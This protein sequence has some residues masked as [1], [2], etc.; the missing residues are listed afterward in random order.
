MRCSVRT[1]VLPLRRLY[2]SCDGMVPVKRPIMLKRSLTARIPIGY[3]L[4]DTAEYPENTENRMGDGIWFG[5][6][7]ASC[8]VMNRADSA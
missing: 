3:L 4:D 6:D 7:W 5:I 1:Y 8:R 2:P